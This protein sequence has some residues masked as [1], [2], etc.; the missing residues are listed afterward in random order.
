MYLTHEQ[1]PG[2]VKKHVLGTGKRKV[3]AKLLEFAIS[4]TV[5]NYRVVD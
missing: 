2:Q 4:V 3:A 1:S 5:I